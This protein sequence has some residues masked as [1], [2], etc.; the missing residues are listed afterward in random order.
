MLWTKPLWG[1]SFLSSLFVTSYTP[2]VVPVPKALTNKRDLSWGQSDGGP[3][4]RGWGAAVQPGAAVAWGGPGSS[5]LCLQRSHGGDGAG[6]FTVV[7]SERARDDGHKLKQ[8]VQQWISGELFLCE[9]SQVVSQA[10]WD[11]QSST[12][13]VWPSWMRPY[14]WPQ[15]QPP[16]R[17]RLDQRPPEVPPSRNDPV[18]LWMSRV[19]W[20][21]LPVLL[22]GAL[23]CETQQMWAWFGHW[24]LKGTPNSSSVPMCFCFSLTSN[25]IF[26]LPPQYKTTTKTLDTIFSWLLLCLV[27]LLYCWFQ[28]QHLLTSE[29]FCVFTVP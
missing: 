22:R 8:E 10:T 15:S 29:S 5:T 23:W 6:L 21:V 18:S 27:F 28:F 20:S 4:R 3:A 14:I 19:G 25:Q 17:R 11:V 2:P 16:V 26:S 12:L 13:G 24:L 7:Q 1:K 9:D